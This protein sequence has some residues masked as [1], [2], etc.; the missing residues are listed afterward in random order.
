MIIFTVTECYISYSGKLFK[1]SKGNFMVS[2]YVYF[3][4]KVSGA[5][6][7]FLHFLNVYRQHKTWRIITSSGFGSRVTLPCRTNI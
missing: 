6:L 4:N 2:F 3:V 5:V 7:P 1:S